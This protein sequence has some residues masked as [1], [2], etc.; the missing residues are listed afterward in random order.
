M[1]KDSSLNTP[2]SWKW[3][4]SPSLGVKFKNGT[5]STSQNPTVKFTKGGTYNV[6]M[7]ASNAIGEDQ[8]TKVN[9]LFVID[10]IP[11]TVSIQTN[12]AIV[13]VNDTFS[14][15]SSL[16]SNGKNINATYVWKKNGISLSNSQ[17]QLY[18]LTP[19][20]TDKYQLFVQSTVRCV[21]PNPAQSA[22]VSPQIKGVKTISVSCN[23]DTLKAVN[24]GSG[25]YNWYR[26]GIFVGSGQKF[27]PSQTGLYRCVYDENGC[28]SDSSAIIVL[29]SLSAKA[30]G[31]NSVSIYPNPANNMIYISG[32]MPQGVLKIWN[33]VGTLMY[34]SDQLVES[35]TQVNVRD[36]SEGIYYVEL[37]DNSGNALIRERI[38]VQP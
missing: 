8:L 16:L 29:K 28:K 37:C 19:N 11:V 13:C 6:T 34:V 20:A 15:A 17:A 38:V 2:T 7:I 24:G 10:S 14:I 9:R 23:L 30:L 32:L 5:D 12:P 33:S 22:V 27:K 21:V 3:R 18:G 4:F 35:K 31:M 25:T 36:W 26:N 1:F